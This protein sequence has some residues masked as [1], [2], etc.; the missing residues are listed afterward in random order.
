MRSD[1]MPEDLRPPTFEEVAA[2]I[3]EAGLIGK[4]S[5]QHFYEYYEKQDFKYKGI[6]MD[7]QLK[8]QQWASRQR[9]SVIITAKDYAA[10]NNEQKKDAPVSVDAL[11]KLV[12]MI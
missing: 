7:W 3:K 8:I 2:Y 1:S 9:G 10:F 11:R 12:D 4:V 6:I 5:P